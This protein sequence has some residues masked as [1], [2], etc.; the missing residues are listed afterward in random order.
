M[1]A[2]SELSGPPNTRFFV[3]RE[4]EET[5]STNADLLQ[6]AAEGAPEGLVLLARHQRSGRGRQGRRWVDSAGSAMLVSWLLRPK[7]QS[8]SLLPLLTGLAVV[9]ALSG[10]FGVHVGV[11]WPNDILAREPKGKGSGRR[12]ERK[13]AGILAEA[14]SQG[15]DVA[16]VIGVGLNLQFGSGGQVAGGIDLHTLLYADCSAPALPTA[17]E[18]ASVI[19][20]EVEFQLNKLETLGPA[21]LVDQYRQQ[22][23]TLG[24]QV[25]METPSGPLQ[26]LAVDINAA[27]GLVLRTETGLVS[28]SAGDAH[29]LPPLA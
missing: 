7:K 29:H 4:V 3:I 8:L 9:D 2:Q 19:L 11:K 25:R 24:R 22:C 17:S 10:S 23:V 20:T 21:Q 14:S 28:V 16:V 26:G 12:E 6:E 5:G 18:L 1:S 27:G 13:L 15:A